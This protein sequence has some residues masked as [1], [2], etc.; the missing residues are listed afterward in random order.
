MESLSQHRRS[1]EKQKIAGNRTVIVLNG[2][3]RGDHPDFP[4]LAIWKLFVVFF[5]VFVWLSP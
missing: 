2:K 1:E 3:I 4:H 5:F